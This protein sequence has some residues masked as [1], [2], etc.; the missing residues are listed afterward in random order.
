MRIAGSVLRGEWGTAAHR[1]GGGEPGDEA[2]PGPHETARSKATLPEAERDR[3]IPPPVGEGGERLEAVPCARSC[4][5]GHGSDVGSV[6]LQRLA[7]DPNPSRSNGDGL[8]PRKEPVGDRI[9]AIASQPPKNTPRARQKPSSAPTDVLHKSRDK[10]AQESQKI[11]GI[12]GPGQKSK[13]F[14]DPDGHGS[15]G[16]TTDGEVYECYR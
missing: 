10:A 2:V 9:A 14:T 7:V 11:T 4:E 6:S 5:S 13:F 8:E 16:E 12:L 15:D 1:T 3:G